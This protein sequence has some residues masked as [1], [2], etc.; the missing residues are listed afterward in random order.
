MVPLHGCGGRGGGGESAPPKLI[1][2]ILSSP[3]MTKLIVAQERGF[4]RRA[5]VCVRLES[6]TAGMFALQALLAGSLD[7]AVS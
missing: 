6:F 2:G 5:G 4:S 1:V 3:A 7:V